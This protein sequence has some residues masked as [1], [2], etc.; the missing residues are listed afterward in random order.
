M[1]GVVKK[2][3]KSK[4]DPCGV[5][6]KKVMANSLICS[7]YNSWIHAK[8]AKILKVSAKLAKDFICLKCKSSTDF[9]AQPVESLCD[10]IEK[11]HAFLYIGSKVDSIGDCEATVTAR[12]SSDWA[13]FKKCNDILSKFLSQNQRTSLCKL[14]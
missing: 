3:Q 5:C 9:S 2:I 6:C 4:V 1:S 10:G 12:M 7:K 14:C 11:V 13:K 8:C